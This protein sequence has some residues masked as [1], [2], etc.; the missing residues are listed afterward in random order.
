MTLQ[1]R[2]QRIRLL[3]LDVDGVL[4]DGGIVHGSPELETKS[5]H[6]RDGS[7]LTFWRRAGHRSAV[8]TGRCS[9]LVD[10][11]AREVAIDFVFQGASDKLDVY[12]KLL[13]QTGMAATETCYV[14]DDLPDVPVLR[15]CGLAAA[16]ADACPEVR[17][18]AHYITRSAGGRGAVREVIELILRCQGRW[19]QLLERLRNS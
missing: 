9:P 19:R 3:V 16:V 12:Q 14:G 11:R 15:H 2:C 13:E 10:R 7:A 1:E 8:I 18:D 5:F 4:T 17:A 6:V